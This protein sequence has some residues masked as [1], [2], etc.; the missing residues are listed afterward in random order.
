MIVHAFLAAGLAVAAAG[1]DVVGETPPAPAAAGANA[2]G[3]PGDKITMNLRGVPLAQVLESFAVEYRMSIVAGADV[4]GTV[5]MNLF[6]VPAEEALRAVLAV[7]GYGYRKSGDMF[8]VERTEKLQASAAAGEKEEIETRVVRLNY[9]RADEA[10]KLVTPLKTEQGVFTAG[11]PPEDGIESDATRAGGNQPAS[12]EIVVLKDV[13]SVLDAVTKVLADLDRRPR[14]VLVEA[15]I[16][17][18]KLD[19]NTTLGVDFNSL[20]G[21]NFA[22][23]SG[24]SNFNSVSTAAVKGAQ[25][26]DNISSVGTFGFASDANTDGLHFG[27]LTDDVALFVEALEKVTDTSVLANPRVLVVDRQRAEIIIGAK[28]GYKTS[29]TTETSTVQ[30]VQFLDVGTQLRFRPFISD[31]GFVRL[32]IHPESSTGVVDPVSGLP[33]ESTT[34]VTTNVLVKDGNTICIG[35]LIGDQIET[36]TKQIPGLGDIPYLGVIFRRTDDKVSR[37]EVIVLLTPHVVDGGVRDDAGLLQADSMANNRDMILWNQ[38]PISRERLARGWVEK[39][40]SALDAGD[41][42]KAWRCAE[43]ALD[44]IPTDV[45]ATKVRRRALAALGLP[46]QETRALE[47]LEG[48][49]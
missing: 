35:G 9:L 46:D 16:L 30:D 39:A 49:R 6:E 47:A 27:I 31:D 17:E 13:R 20:D 32:E 18:V 5:T 22:D 26:A 34:E 12:G 37:R 11:S 42:R 7:N 15:T 10:I 48:L 14:Q 28:L 44:F 36:A 2:G 43:A 40:E 24:L 41:A 4:T 33:S 29:T 21:I 1:G 8:L 23:L 19:D 25:F 3:A 45:H 38:L